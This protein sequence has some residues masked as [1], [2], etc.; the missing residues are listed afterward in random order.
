[1]IKL[2]VTLTVP[3][4]ET[5]PASFLP[6]SSSIKCSE[7]SFLS[8]SKSLAKKL[9]SFKF[10]PLGLVPAIGLTVILLSLNLTKISGLAP[11]I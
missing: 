2:S 5:L 10:L 7:S 4:L 8:L 11:I 1:M 9:S 6:K 3:I